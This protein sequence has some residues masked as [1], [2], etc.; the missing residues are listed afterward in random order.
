MPAAVTLLC[1]PFIIHHLK[2]L[3]QTACGNLL[4]PRA[5]GKEHL[6]LRLDT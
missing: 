3:A 1:V 5:A 2:L 6:F 4:H